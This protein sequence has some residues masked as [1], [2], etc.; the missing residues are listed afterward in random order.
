LHAIPLIASLVDAPPVDDAAF[1]TQ[2]TFPTLKDVSDETLLDVYRLY[3]YM[4]VSPRVIHVLVIEWAQRHPPAP[5]VGS[6]RTYAEALGTAWDA[7]EALNGHARQLWVDVGRRLLRGIQDVAQRIG[8]A[9]VDLLGCHRPLSDEQLV[10]AMQGVSDDTSNFWTLITLAAFRQA[11]ALEALPLEVWDFKDYRRHN[12]HPLLAA[13][14]SG[15]AA[16]LHVVDKRLSERP[17]RCPSHAPYSK[18]DFW[19]RYALCAGAAAAGDLD[20]VRAML[21]TDETLWLVA[22]KG[23]L[24]RAPDT[25]MLAALVPLKTGSGTPHIQILSAFVDSVRDPAHVDR[26]PASLPVLA[27]IWDLCPRRA[28]LTDWLL[29]GTRHSDFHPTKPASFA[30]GRAV[31]QLLLAHPPLEDPVGLWKTCAA[32]ESST[33]LFAQLAAA[34]VQCPPDVLRAVSKYAI[35]RDEEGW[36]AVEWLV[37]RGAVW[38]DQ[39]TERLLTACT[40]ARRAERLVTV[41]ER[42]DA[43]GWQLSVGTLDAVGARVEGAL[44]TRVDALRARRVGSAGAGF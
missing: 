31:V 4:Q 26:V 40:S 28:V 11:A 15:D 27:W 39:C 32:S 7:R 16:T 41:L 8:M 43:R 2:P 18:H 42:V 33:T 13:S 37:A 22:V 44:R 3:E 21:P 29:S 25:S 30:F 17:V 36:D 1:A 10:Q 12:E 34:K 35:L 23:A 14:W 24:W 6:K 38:T 9:G 5:L 19:C 20:T